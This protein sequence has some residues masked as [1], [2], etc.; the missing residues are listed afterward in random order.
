MISVAACLVAMLILHLLTPY[1]WWVMVV[2]FAFGTAFGGSGWKAFRTGF[3]SAG[4]LWAA[5]AGWFYLTG[6]QL[7]TA[8]MAAMFKLGRPALLIAAAALAAAVAAGISGY[9]GFAV[10]SLV[11]PR[12]ARLP[13]TERRKPI[14]PKNT[15][16][17]AP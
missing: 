13:E 4:I 5:A 6:A 14:M 2:P 8:R 7:I 15:K 10:R 12:T 16:D 11:R 1:W 17:S 9:A 3:V